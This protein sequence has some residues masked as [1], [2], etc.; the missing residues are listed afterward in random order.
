[1]QQGWIAVTGATGYV[2][3]RLVG[4]LLEEGYQVRALGRS[5]E[6]LESRPWAHHP[7]VQL[8][9]M[10]V[11]NKASTEKA[12]QGCKVA[13]YFI[14]SMNPDQKDFVEEDRQAATLFVAAAESAQL[15][16]IIYLGGL[17]K[18]PKGKDELSEHLKSRREVE[19]LLK[20]G[21]V[22]V[23]VFRAA[24]IIGSGSASF[25]ILRYL[26]ERL[27]IMITPKWVQTLN[28]PIGIRN[29]LYYLTACLTVEETVGQTFDIGGPDIVTYQTLMQTYRKK[30]GLNPA[31]I[32][33][34]PVFS[35][36]LSSYWIHLITPVSAALARPLAQGLKNEV[37]MEDTRI[38]T[39]IPQPLLTV[40]ES[41]QLA[42]KRTQAGAVP[43]HWTDAGF[44]PDP[45]NAYLGDPNWSG[46]S[47]FVDKRSM[48]VVADRAKLW[49]QVVK[50]GGATGW[51]YGNWLWALR[52]IMDIVF[53]GI[54]LRQGR[55]HADD[56]HVGDALDCWRVIR[57]KPLELLTLN[58]EMKVPGKAILSFE[59]RETLPGH[60]DLIQTAVFRPK[61]LMG[62]AYWYAV[63][64]LHAFV[65]DG[66]LKGIITAGAFQKI[67]GP[68]KLSNDLV[69][70]KPK[71]AIQ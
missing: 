13:Y 39:L 43:S 10:N 55:R 20:S 25:E 18:E 63:S 52:G 65:F 67:K 49:K 50:I 6:K 54:G 7:N 61:G 42:L 41:I 11:F 28:Q 66:M 57:L 19:T 62:L 51:Y 71:Q 15:Q 56:L 70:Q 68:L 37:I 45:E 23:T 17:G 3:A 24:M 31:W 46:G 32:I 2:G 8:C 4:Q 9:T 59:I 14:H 40:E 35:I 69:L 27:P 34:V 48:S 26:S 33:P 16:R 47:V 1:M 36:T 29:V 53:G 21:T 22:P 38:Q 44:L 58:A 5:L 12:L 30:A 60:C 64:P